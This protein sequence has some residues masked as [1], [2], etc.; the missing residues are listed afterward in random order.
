[1]GVKIDN[2]YFFPTFNS[3]KSISCLVLSTFYDIVTLSA[4]GRCI[5]IGFFVFIKL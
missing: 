1:M 4:L 2:Y 3:K 5:R